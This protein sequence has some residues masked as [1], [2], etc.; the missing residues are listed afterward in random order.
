[1]AIV[2]PLLAHGEQWTLHSPFTGVEAMA[3]TRGRVYYASQG[4]LYAYDKQDDETILYNNVNGL[5]DVTVTGL[6]SPANGNFVA[7]AYRNGN[8]DLIYDN[9]TVRNLPD[10]KDSR[11]VKKGINSI[12]FNADASAMLAAT[13]FGTVRFNVGKGT[14]TDSG[15]FDINIGHAAFFNG[16]PVIYLDG[17]LLILKEGGNIKNLDSWSQC[18]EIDLLSLSG[19]GDALCG[20]VAT[21]N[22]NYPVLFTGLGPG[23][24]TY[25]RLTTVPADII[26]KGNTNNRIIVSVAG[27]IAVFDNDFRQ[28]SSTSIPAALQGH[29]FTATGGPGDLWFGTEKGIENIDLTSVPAHSF[30]TI[31]PGG[32]GV[33]EIHLLRKAPSG[34]IYA[35]NRGNSNIFGVT[36]TDIQGRQALITPDGEI[37]D[38]T[39]AGLTLTQYST[40]GTTGSLTDQ[41]FMRENPDNQGTY[42]TGGLHEGLYLLSSD[43][44]EELAHYYDK[45]SRLSDYWGVRAQDALVDDAGYLW[46]LSERD[47]GAP[48]L[49]RLSPEGRRKGKEATIAD[50]QLIDNTAPF[51]AARD[52]RL[53][54]SADGRY[55]YAMGKND[56]MVYDTNG[57]PGLDDD[58]MMHAVNFLMSDGMGYA[59]FSRFNSMMEDPVTG[60]LWVA[61]AE[62][63]FYIPAPA[64]I[65][66]GSVDIVKPKVA[67]NDGTD[68]ADYL[69]STQCVYDI[70][71][72]YNG[73]KWF[74]TRDSGIFLT[75]D[76]GTRII[77]NYNT[78]NSP[79]PS[80]TVFSTQAADNGKIYFGTQYGLMELASEY[81][82]PFSG[83]DSLKIFPNPVRPGYY[84]D[85]TI[86]GV[87]AGSTVKILSASGRLV[88]EIESEGSV[89]R[90]SARGAGGARVAAGI[91]NV[92]VSSSVH[93]NKSAGKIVILR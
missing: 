60:A 22:G 39:P 51:Y 19:I 54:M 16:K 31:N 91:Y 35:G 10:I 56:L 85:V 40:A 83:Y 12:E 77:K 63:V 3:E 25:R 8:I 79:L 27:N 36:E 59:T 23:D 34:N 29:L 78:S 68:L 6:Y 66:N 71:T 70:S 80:N 30:A 21:E 11:I 86:E 1:M 50:W 18:G 92:M 62:G 2:V 48:S 58:R 65:V 13:E 20:I 64:N 15:I 82:A 89:A 44:G 17:R 45:N 32:I 72:D 4:A 47:P 28:L 69:L 90:W 42:Y 38:I 55:L 26:V 75:T 67:R 9:G 73:N 88:A 76:D 74:V 81:S 53:E 43:T 49:M 14:V 57:T 46:V 52:A 37:K 5:H 33:K 7:V 87:P 24:I 84:G 61:T 93:G 41:L